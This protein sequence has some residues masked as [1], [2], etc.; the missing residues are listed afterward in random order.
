[1]V[2][3]ARCRPRSKWRAAV[4]VVLAGTKTIYGSHHKLHV[5]KLT[6]KNPIQIYWTEITA[7]LGH[8]WATDDWKWRDHQGSIT[9]SYLTSSQEWDEGWAEAFIWLRIVIL[10]GKRGAPH[11]P[12]L[13]STEERWW[14]LASWSF[15]GASWE[16]RGAPTSPVITSIANWLL[17][18]MQNGLFFFF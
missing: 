3:P 7:C 2:E 17:T 18:L 8:L 11:S 16:T 15:T 4:P 1:M 14:L 13:F 10:A 5:V 9:L 12:S 6:P